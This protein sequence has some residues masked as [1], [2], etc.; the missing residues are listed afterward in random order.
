MVSR[1][2]TGNAQIPARANQPILEPDSPWISALG[3]SQ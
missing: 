2:Q 1:R 3:V